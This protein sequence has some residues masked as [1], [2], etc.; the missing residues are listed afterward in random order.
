MYS[1]ILMDPPW[2]ETGGGKIKRGAHSAK[3]PEFYELIEARSN[4]PYLEMFARNGRDGWA[5]W[6]N[7]AP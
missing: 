4:G 2:Y 1:T 5:S 3:P 6:G 7:E